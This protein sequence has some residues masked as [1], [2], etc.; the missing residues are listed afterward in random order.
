MATDDASQLGS[1]PPTDAFDA[2]FKALGHGSLNLCPLSLDG[3]NRSLV[4][5]NPWSDDGR[6]R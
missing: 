4:W 1:L 5:W 2:L 6:P 3:H